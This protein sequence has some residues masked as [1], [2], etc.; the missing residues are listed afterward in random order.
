MNVP[1][2]EATQFKDLQRQL[3][4]VW[5]AFQEDPSYEH[6]SVIVPSMTVNQEEL[7]KVTGAA[8]L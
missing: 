2:A 8:F 6:T 5:H 4:K 1:E 7:A 3:K